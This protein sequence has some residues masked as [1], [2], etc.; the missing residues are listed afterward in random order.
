VT[1]ERNQTHVADG[2]LKFAAPFWG[3]PRWAALFA[4]I[5]RQIQ[6]VEDV[7]WNVI[8]SRFLSNATGAQLRMLGRLVGQIDPGLGEEIFRNL[9]RVRIRINRSDG[10]RNDVLEVL[11]LLGIPLAQRTV[12]NSFPAK[13]KVDLSGVLPLPLA[14]LTQLLNDTLSAGVGCVVV[15]APTDEGFSF[16]DNTGV[17]G[18]DQAWSDNSG[19]PG[20]GWATVSQV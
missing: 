12:T 1:F 14:L 17:P 8:V 9:I 15:Y 7:A 19:V 4:A 13:I 18:P 10:A 20:S 2:V 6:E 16:S 5:G 3:K 11:Q